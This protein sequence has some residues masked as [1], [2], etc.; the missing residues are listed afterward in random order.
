MWAFVFVGLYGYPFVEVGKNMMMLPQSRG[1]T[2]IITNNLEQGVL[3][4][5][6]MAIGLIMGLVAMAIANTG[7]MVFGN[8]VGASAAAFFVSFITGA[9]LAFTLLTLVSSAVNT[10]IVCY[11]EAP[12]EFE[13]NHPKLSQDMLSA[14]REAWPEEF[15]Y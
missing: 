12:R 8:E 4:L 10:V 1:W 11:A 5:V 2:A 14:W 13:L 9:V 15:G 3:G 6:S 7:G